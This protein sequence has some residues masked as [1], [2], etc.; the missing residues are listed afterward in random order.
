MAPTRS[1]TGTIVGQVRV[2]GHVRRS[3]PLTVYKNRH[4]C[5]TS[6]KDESILVGDD[7][8]VE[9]VVV[10]VGG[11]DE[12]IEKLSHTI[13]LDNK[14]CKFSPHVQAVSVGSEILLHNSDPILHDVHARVN[15]ETLFNVGLPSWRQV[16]KRLTVPGIITIG[17]EVLHTWMSAFI[18]VTSSRY[19]AVT[20]STGQFT[21]GGVPA[22]VYELEFWHEKLGRM[23]RKVVVQADQS[24]M[25]EVVFTSPG[26]DRGAEINH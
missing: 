3:E 18:V 8:A 25:V 6:V 19:F 1:R 22:G 26:T 16:K 21:L 5:G 4:F 23:S 17:C 11:V 9:N 2:E 15:S 7:G 14:D 20:D 10:I 13:V 24:A 12:V